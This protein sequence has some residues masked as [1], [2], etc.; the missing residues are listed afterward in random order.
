MFKPIEMENLPDNMPSVFDYI[1]LDVLDQIS[2]L[3]R[4]WDNKFLLYKPLYAENK[5]INILLYG[6]NRK[7][8]N[9]LFSSEYDKSYS[10]EDYRKDED[11][12]DIVREEIKEINKSLLEKIDEY[13]QEL[14]IITDTIGVILNKAYIE[15]DVINYNLLRLCKVFASLTY[16]HRDGIDCCD[17]ESVQIALRILDGTFKG[18][19]Y[20]E[21]LDVFELPESYITCCNKGPNYIN[22]HFG[23]L[24]DYGEEVENENTDEIE[25]KYDANK[26]DPLLN[27]YD[28]DNINMHKYDNYD[29]EIQM[30]LEDLIWK[31]IELNLISALQKYG[32]MRPEERTRGTI[33]SIFKSPE[34]YS[35]V[36]E[37]EI[38]S[39]DGI[40]YG[41]RYSVDGEL[42]N[43]DLNI[44]NYDSF[45]DFYIGDRVDF[46]FDYREIYESDEEDD[47]EEDKFKGCNFP[48]NIRK[49]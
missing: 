2:G 33:I 21:Y 38:I 17:F 43:L 23:W 8:C 22:T 36:V 31:A 39:D 7:L 3:I 34:G 41:G 13:K 16:F 10:D 19:K 5:A 20:N 29:Q 11:T 14:D 12:L 30:P 45:K 25:E 6:A 24:N 47:E 37:I 46:F 49:I 15:K 28:L 35:S 9:K 4:A 32:L 44:V 18:G 48:V 42:G 26:I 1:T 27:K 40:K